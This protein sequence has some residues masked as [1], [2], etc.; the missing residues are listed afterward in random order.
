MTSSSPNLSEYI[1]ELTPLALEMLA[2]VKDRRE[3]QALSDRI[4]KLKTDP[5]KQGKPLVDNLQ[6]YF[7]VRAVGQ[8]YRIIYR[9]VQERVVVLVVGVGRRKE[10]D[11]KDIYTIMERLLAE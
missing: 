2:E 1:I 7:S 5:D 9:I 4:D 3:Q 8:R 11:K 6:G 10:G